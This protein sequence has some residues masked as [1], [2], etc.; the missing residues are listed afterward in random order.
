MVF[1]ISI[2]YVVNKKVRSLSYHAVW[3]CH[4]CTN[5]II[6]VRGMGSGA[7]SSCTDRMDAVASCRAETDLV[8]ADRITVTT[9]TCPCRRISICSMHGEVLDTTSV[10]GLRTAWVAKSGP[11]FLCSGEPTARADLRPTHGGT[12][13]SDGCEP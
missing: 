11:V 1:A 4:S 6:E 5:Q 12:V 13:H 8:T 10:D 3:G 2:N 9:Q 7:A